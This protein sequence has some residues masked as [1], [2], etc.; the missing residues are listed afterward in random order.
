TASPTV[1][2]TIS[3]VGILNNSGTKQNLVADLIPAPP[4]PPQPDL[5]GII[6]FTNSA[7]AGS[8]TVFTTRG[9][10]FNSGG[11]IEFTNN[12]NAG[13]ADFVNNGAQQADG[14][15]GVTLFF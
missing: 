14:G 2:L 6:R 5:R 12:S 9:G 7:V 1:T 8:D 15:G 11:Q 13:S 4:F 10:F 3:G